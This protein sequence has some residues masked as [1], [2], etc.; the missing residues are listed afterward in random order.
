MK[1]QY[2]KLP[3]EFDLALLQQ[4]LTHC[5]QWQWSDHFNKADYNGTWKV[6]ALRSQNGTSDHIFANESPDATFQNTPLLEQCPYF[7]SILDQFECEKET[8]RLLQLAEDSE[9]KEHRDHKLGY[10][11]G[12][13]RIHIPLQTNEQV[14]FYVNSIPL[15]MQV[16]EC[17]YLNFNLPHRVLNKGNA[18]RIHLVMDCRRNAWSDQLFQQMGYDFECESTLQQPTT[19]V[20]VLQRMIEELAHL[21]GEASERLRETLQQQMNAQ[22]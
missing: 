12:I 5:L 6:I 11:D 3:F 14:W 20:Q 21:P 4:D 1:N 13:F 10:E 19:S 2:F 22:L 15:Q 8:I 7:K 16:G 18:P 9:I 17:W